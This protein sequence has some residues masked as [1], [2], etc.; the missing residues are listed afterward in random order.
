VSVK[1][2]SRMANFAL[3]FLKRLR[4][5]KIIRVLLSLS[6]NSAKRF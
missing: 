6:F 1:P 3:V 2:L 4:I 5:A